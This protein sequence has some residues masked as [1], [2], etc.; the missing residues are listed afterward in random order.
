M[1]RKDVARDDLVSV[2]ENFLIAVP[3][4]ENYQGISKNNIV[5]RFIFCEIIFI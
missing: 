5:F 1:N 2:P 4:Q 3:K